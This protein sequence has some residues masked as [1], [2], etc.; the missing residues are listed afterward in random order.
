MA[1]VPIASRGSSCVC[2]ASEGT[3]LGFLGLERGHARFGLHA[4]INQTEG[5]V[6]CDR[7]ERRPTYFGGSFFFPLKNHKKHKNSQLPSFVRLFNICLPFF[8]IY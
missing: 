8:C 3:C 5:G 6:R 1:L 4:K 2:L 7:P